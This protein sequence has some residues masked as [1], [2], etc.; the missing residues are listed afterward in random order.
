MI[1]GRWRRPSLVEDFPPTTL[2]PGCMLEPGGE[3]PTSAV[4]SGSCAMCW[5]T[6]TVLWIFIGK[7]MTLIESIV[8]AD[9]LYRLTWK[10][11]SSKVVYLSLLVPQ[12]I[13]YVHITGWGGREAVHIC[14][15]PEWYRDISVANTTDSSHYHTQCRLE[16]DCGKH[17]FWWVWL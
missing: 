3:G 11:R 10:V 9:M 14:P 12:A 13:Q 15:K 7:W 4:M 8:R 1:C 2:F 17:V 16:L 6:T 5:S